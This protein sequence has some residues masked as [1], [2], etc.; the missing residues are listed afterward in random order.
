[1]MPVISSPTRSWYSSNIMSRSAS[2]IRWRIT[3]L[4]VWAAIRPKSVGV[5]SRLEIWSSYSAS[6]SGPISGSSGS[7]ISPV[8]GSIVRSSSIA[9]ATSFSS[10]SGGRISSN[11]RKSAVERSMSTRAYFAAPGV[12]L[13]ADSSASS[14]ASMSFSDEMPFSFSRVWTA[15]TI[16]LLNLSSSR[17]LAA[18]SGWNAGCGS[19]ECGPSPSPPRARRPR[20]RRPRGRP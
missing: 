9:S 20:R 15:S 18:K 3:C 19:A 17:P 1:M 16:S 8:S 6:L 14:S 13:Y 2:R 5:T 12:F 4:A 10:S 7:R 11:T